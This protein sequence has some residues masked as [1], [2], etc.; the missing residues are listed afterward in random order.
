RDPRFLRPRLPRQ[1]RR[2]ARPLRDAVVPGGPAGHLRP[3]LHAALRHRPRAHDR[4]DRRDGGAGLPE[5]AG[6]ERHQRHAGRGGPGAVLALWLQR[7]SWRPRHRARALARRRVRQPG[8]AVGRHHRGRRRPLSARFHSAAREP[9]GRELRAGHALLRR[10]DQR[11]GPHQ[12][13]RLHQVAGAGEKLMSTTVVVETAELERS[14]LTDKVS[15]ASW[16]LATDHKR[17]AILYL[18]SITFFFF[19]GGFA[20]ALV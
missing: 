7:L 5:M 11:G 4:Q 2:A 12:A 15:I 9:G 10:P 6:A 13:H 14:Y 3:V 1:A 18:G 16:L 17:I 19:I 20:A 8:A